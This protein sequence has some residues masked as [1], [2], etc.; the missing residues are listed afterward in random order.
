MMHKRI[1][2]SIHDVTPYY[3]KQIQ[4]MLGSL[5]ERN[6]KKYALLIS[7]YFEGVSLQ[8]SPAL[9]LQLKRAERRGAEL[10]LHGFEHKAK[11]FAG[12]KSETQLILENAE[13]AYLDVFNTKPRGF[14]PACWNISTDGKQTLKENGYAFTET[15]DA[16]EF[17]SGTIIKGWPLGME[18][19]SN[20][21]LFKYDAVS[22]HLTRWFTQVHARLMK[23][24]IVRFTLHP[25]EVDTDNFKASLR[26][27][28][29]LLADGW[30]P[31]TY[32]ELEH[33]I[34]SS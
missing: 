11:E 30:K 27:L 4:T 19:L 15:F 7:P 22:H 8:K 6:I 5:D 9:I 2:I 17:F 25:R 24:E 33:E 10:M 28:D 23:K 1:L 31:I 13:K 14:I 3:E 12:S 20:N 18:S 21:K 29:V 16:I 34:L 26:L 32:T